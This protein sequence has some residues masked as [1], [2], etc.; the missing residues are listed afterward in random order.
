MRA[1]VQRVKEAR[2]TVDDKTTGEIAHGLLVLLGVHKDDTLEKL[3]WAAKKITSLR[4]FS[5]E[6]EKFQH[7]LAHV[8]GQILVVSQFTLFGDCTRGR[9]PEFLNAAAPDKALEFYEH[10]LN[11]VK[12]LGFSPH[13]GRFGAKMDVHSIND[14]PVTLILE[15]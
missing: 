5:D 2:V 7:D 8:G 13:S 14:G 9:R 6:E 10:F 11:A 12:K 15:R 1:V 4:I 3:D